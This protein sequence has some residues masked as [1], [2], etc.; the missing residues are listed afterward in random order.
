MY[1]RRRWFVEMLSVWEISFLGGM[2][3]KFTHKDE[4]ARVEYVSMGMAFWWWLEGKR[5]FPDKLLVSAYR[6]RMIKH[7]CG[8]INAK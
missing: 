4:V 6:E 7:I 1:E 2:C 3:T 8:S 5:N